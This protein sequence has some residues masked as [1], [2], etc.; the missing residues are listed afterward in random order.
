MKTPLL[1]LFCLVGHSLLARPIRIVHFNIKELSSEKIRNSGPQLKSVQKI[2]QSMDFDLL[3]I[4]E[5]Q[6][7][8]PGIPNKSLTT[9]GQNIQIF[10]DFLQL[11]QPHYQF[12]FNQANTGNNARKK[13]DGTYYAD[14]SDPKSRLAADL[15]NFGIFPGQYSS[16]L[17]TRY[18][19]V[20]EKVITHLKW[21]DF[22]PQLD[23]GQFAKAN[24][25]PLPDEMPLFDKNLTDL[26][27]EVDGRL[28]HVVSLHTVPYFHFGNSKTPNYQRNE[29]QLRFLEW[30]L[31]GKTDRVVQLAGIRPIAAGAP[32]IA[33]GDWNV[34]FNTVSP[35][36]TILQRLFSKM[37]M[38]LDNPP[39]TYESKGYN[40]KLKLTLD[41]IIFSRHFDLI[42]AGVWGA[43]GHPQELA[44][45]ILPSSPPKANQSLV[46]YQEGKKVC[47]S[48]MSKDYVLAKQASDHFP[49]YT[50]LQLK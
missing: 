41:Y 44:C 1:L 16:A 33:M 38:W 30:Y 35:A 46:A 11:K 25:H 45:G 14:F 10:L 37:Q 40:P 21:K 36:A 6:Y 22:N 39:H 8:L 15:V 31:T 26:Q 50:T 24:G 3:S 29:D 32:I 4:Q 42:N 49:I 43:D 48:S 5:M 28:I 17:A 18:R 9:Q 7:D 13:K 34:D 2:L 23:L 20:N 47:Y 19:I 12:S 27:V